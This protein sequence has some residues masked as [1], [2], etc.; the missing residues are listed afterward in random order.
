M[1]SFHDH[2]VYHYLCRRSVRPRHSSRR[3][4][5]FALRVAGL[6]LLMGAIA[7]LWRWPELS[8]TFGWD[9]TPG[10][11]LEAAPRPDARDSPDRSARVVYAYSV[12]PGGVTGADEVRRAAA[13]DP[14]VGEHYRD[15]NLARLTTVSLKADTVAYVS[16]RKGDKVYWTTK[17]VRLS[18]GETVLTDGTNMVRARCGNRISDASMARTAPEEPPEV[19]LNTPLL[20][21]GPMAPLQLPGFPEQARLLVTAMPPQL[22]EPP[23]PLPETPEEI[24]SSAPKD[25]TLTPLEP[26]GPL[27]PYWYGFP[28]PGYIAWWGPTPEPPP[29]QPP[30]KPVGQ[31]G[32]GDT[33]GTSSDSQDAYTPEPSSLLL[34]GAGMLGLGGLLARA[35]RRRNR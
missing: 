11:A 6:L 10:P 34:V 33:T 31:G 9:R 21:G 8:Y 16:F 29:V 13:A 24:M 7:L 5:L 35:H 18:K 22:P 12:V 23:P 3:D 25:G 14:V 19:E 17:K 26:D 27:G 20:P 30:K 32:S 28:S 4:E 1:A 15:L 2:N